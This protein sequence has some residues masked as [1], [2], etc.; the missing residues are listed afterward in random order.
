MLCGN[1]MCSKWFSRGTLLPPSPWDPR[2]ISHV[3]FL[4]TEETYY[5]PFPP[6][7][8]SP[9]WLIVVQNLQSTTG[10]TILSRPSFVVFLFAAMAT[11]MSALRSAQNSVRRSS[12][13]SSTKL[14]AMDYIKL[15]DSDLQVSKVCLGTM[16]FGEQNT[17]QDGCD[18][19]D[20]AFKEY[21]VNFLDT[22]ELYSVPTRA[23]TQ[24][25]TDR[26]IA[27]WLKGQDRSKVILASKVSGNA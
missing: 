1:R 16:T 13:H 9:F 10:M 21:G 6:L 5:T 26:I 12:I 11:I 24:G 19:L 15:G 22:A 23:E 20:V 3:P 27:K 18:Q 14:R 17:L 25:A 8:D 7:S 4:M 2:R